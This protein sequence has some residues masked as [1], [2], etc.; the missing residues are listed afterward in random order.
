MAANNAL[1]MNSCSLIQFSCLYSKAVIQFILVY[2]HLLLS[3]LSF[4]EKEAFE[5]TISNCSSLKMM[6]ISG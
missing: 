6:K 5:K 4:S 3:D 2:H 1:T